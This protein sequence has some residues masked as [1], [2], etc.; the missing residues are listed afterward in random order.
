[1]SDF[2][3]D[4]SLALQWFLEDEADRTYSLSL[5]ASLKIARSFPF[6]GSMKLAMGC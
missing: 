1:V 2:V 6:S 4:A 5:R 3:L